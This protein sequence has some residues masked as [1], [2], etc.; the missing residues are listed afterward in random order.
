VNISSYGEQCASSDKKE[1][2]N[3][4]SVMPHGMWAKSGNEQLCSQLFTGK[5]GINVNLVEPSNTLEY[6]EL[7]CAP[8]I[9]ELI[10]KYS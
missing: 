4:N 6:F 10:K 7:F 8:E 3:D 1:N 9:V 2:K 5:L